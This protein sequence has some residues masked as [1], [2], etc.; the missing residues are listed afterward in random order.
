M[1]VFWLLARGQDLPILVVDAAAVVPLMLLVSMI[2]VAI[3]GWGV[4]EGFLVALLRAAGI[5]PESALLLSVSFG[6]VSFLASL[7]GVV[8]LGLSARTSANA[9]TSSET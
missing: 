2:P 8:L 1:V 5:G 6:T 4:R 3:G 7:P 9:A